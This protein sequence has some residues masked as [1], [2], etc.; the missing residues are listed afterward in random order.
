EHGPLPLA[1]LEDEAPLF[2]EVP[3][4]DD[5]CAASDPPAGVRLALRKREAAPE[6]LIGSGEAVLQTMGDA[7]AGPGGE[8]AEGEEEQPV[9]GEGPARQVLAVGSV[10][11]VAVRQVRPAPGRH[12]RPRS[13]MPSRRQNSWI[14]RVRAKYSTRSAT[15]RF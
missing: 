9:L 1:F 3:E 8:Q 10:Q 14:A 4:H 7:E 15:K 12:P 13:A 2:V 11:Q 5:V 6:V